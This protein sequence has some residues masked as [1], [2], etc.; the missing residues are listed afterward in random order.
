MIRAA[1]GAL[2]ALICAAAAFAAPPPLA[3]QAA[4]TPRSLLNAFNPLGSPVPNGNVYLPEPYG[5]S[6]AGTVANHLTPAVAAQ[7]KAAGFDGIRLQISIGPCIQAVK[8]GNSLATLDAAEDAAV[9]VFVNAG[10]GVLISPYLS[11]Y[12]HPTD[13]WKTYLQGLG[14]ADYQ[15]FRTCVVHMAAIEA[16]RDPRLVAMDMPNEPVETGAAAGVTW[17]GTLQPDLDAAIHAAAPNMTRALTSPNYSGLLELAGG[18][19]SGT[20]TP[21]SGLNPTGYTNVLYEFHYFGPAPFAVQGASYQAYNCYNFITGVSF[22]PRASEQAAAVAA[23]TANVNAGPVQDTSCTVANVTQQLA[24]YYAGQGAAYISGLYDQ[25]SAWAA[26]WGVRPSDVLVGEDNAI[27]QGVWTD[28]AGRAQGADRVSRANY[29]AALTAAA[30]AH[31][32]R[33]APDHLDTADIGI[34]TAAGVAI[35]AFDSLHV[36]ALAPPAIKLIRR[37]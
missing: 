14:T 16:G 22:P 10:V 17:L 34:T 25:V 18:S 5:P 31:G 27:R 8:A 7:V 1:L 32:F 37:N 20:V 2:L 15:A 26:Y 33:H 28:Q 9:S 11:G 29:E 24:Y 21:T 23:V 12:V 35:G 6:A 19:Y 36:T 30:V 4:F 13:D 3:D